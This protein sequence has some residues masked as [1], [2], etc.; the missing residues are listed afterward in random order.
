MTVTVLTRVLVEP[1]REVVGLAVNVPEHVVV[2]LLCP[3]KRYIDHA[4]LH[5]SWPPHLC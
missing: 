2:D 3:L 1:V 5:F 4:A